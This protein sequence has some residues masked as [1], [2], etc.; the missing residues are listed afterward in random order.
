M[1][2]P[3]LTSSANKYKISKLLPTIEQT[4]DDLFISCASFEKRCM[5]ILQGHFAKDYT[6]R[7]GCLFKY[8][9]NREENYKFEEDK[10]ANYEQM[11]SLLSSNITD[12]LSSVICYRKEVLDG[13]SQFAVL[14]ETLWKPSGCK[15]VTIDITTFTKLYMLEILHFLMV[16]KK[17][18][19]VCVVYNQAKVYGSS[20]LTSGVGEVICIP[21]FAGKFNV[22][23]ERILIA[24]LGFETERALGIWHAFEPNKTIA[25]IGEPPLRPQYV[26][27]AKERNKFLLGR[28]GVEVKYADPYDPFAMVKFLEEIYNTECLDT[29]GEPCN[30]VIMPLGTKVQALGAFLFWLRH[31]GVRLMYA[32]PQGYGEG[33]STRQPGDNFSYPL[34]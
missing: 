33:Y 26:K 12:I 16:R 15:I 25:I 2:K 6:A 9:S 4:P 28:A 32:F 11:R 18:R 3:K 10:N 19:K 20:L 24:C 13:L 31:R 5:G 22:G 17:V 30:V 7:F 8:E 14:W 29:Q 23:K 34:Y 21:S 27:R 1:K